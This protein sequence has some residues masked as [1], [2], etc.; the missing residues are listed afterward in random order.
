MILFLI[1]FIAGVLTAIAPCVLPLLPVIVGGS[2]VTGERNRAYTISAALGVSVILFT[3]LLK[4]STAFINVP[5]LFWELFSGVILVIF[6]LVM[7]FPR[8][9]DNLGFVNLLNRESNKLL[10]TGYQ[11]NSIWGDA[12]MGAALGPVFSSCSPTYFVILATVLPASF[13]MG[14]A[15][16]FAYAVGLSGFLLLIALAGQKLVDKLGV[17][18]EPGGWFRKAIGILFLIVG[19][20]VATGAES[21]TE[22]WLL[23]H[24]FDLTFI[25]QHL[26]AGPQ[27]PNQCTNGACNSTSSADIASSSPMNKPTDATPSFLS[28]AQKAIRYQKSP[29]LTGIDGYINTDGKPITIGQFKGKKVVLIDI[30]TY[31]CINCQRTLPY[32]KAWYDKYKDQGLEI[33]GVHTPEFAFEHVLANVQQAVNGF[34]IKYPVVLDNEYATWNAFGNQFWPRKYLIDIDGYI[35]YD[36]AGEGNY[37]ETE[38][39]IQKALAERAERLGTTMPTSTVSNPSGVVSVDSS[40]L[41]SPETYFG[42]NRNEYLGNGNVGQQGVQNL[43]IPINRNANTLYL[44]GA[45]NFNGEYA[46]NQSAAATIRYIYKAKNVYF[47]ASPSGG[48]VKIK[49]TRD[50]GKSLGSAKG[51]DVDAN[52]D[53]TI[54]S[55]RLYQLVGDSDYGVHELEIE[56][57]SPGLEAYTFTFG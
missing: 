27:Q 13:A 42:A 39:A 29:E 44:G 30:W 1:S 33:I 52:G 22:A 46:Q 5:Q 48:P 15:D 12:L 53:V 2:A 40:E 57:K 26:L 38:K 16:L 56:V 43:T 47:V 36:H 24:G 55:D 51:A 11:Q 49:V 45:W 7:I 8:L 3:L 35:V 54:D 34:G 41:G 50:G 4:V 9:W 10:S 21:S 20:A 23:S 28:L 17:A 37:D 14:L 25:E 32:I 31:S 19:L 18:I 6:G